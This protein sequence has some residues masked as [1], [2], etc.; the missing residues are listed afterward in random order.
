METE[1]CS[2]GYIELPIKIFMSVSGF[3]G[4][5]VSGQKWFHCMLHFEIQ[6]INV[7]E[8]TQVEVLPLLNIMLCICVDTVAA[9]ELI[10]QC[11]HQEMLY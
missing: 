4:L 2:F 5:T 1:Q 8:C 3:S 7:K 11:F 9:S 6:N 10:S